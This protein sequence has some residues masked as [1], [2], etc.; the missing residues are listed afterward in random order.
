MLPAVPF[1]ERN[2]LA[3]MNTRDWEFPL[4]DDALMSMNEWDT[5]AFDRGLVQAKQESP[6]P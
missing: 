2:S 4:N 1:S 6:D 3:S 5:Y